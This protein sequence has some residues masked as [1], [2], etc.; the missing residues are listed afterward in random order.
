[1]RLLCPG[2]KCI[3]D[4]NTGSTETQVPPAW[5][6]GDGGTEMKGV[7][8]HSL[9]HAVTHSRCH[10]TPHMTYVCVCVC[11]R[12][13]MRV[14][15]RACL[16]ACMRAWVRACVCAHVLFVC[17]F[18]VVVSTEQIPLKQTLQCANM[19]IVMRYQ[20]GLPEDQGGLNVQAAALS[21]QSDPAM[22]QR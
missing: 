20:G 1:M 8:V 5:A 16:R 6:V 15:L 4:K 12:A 19:C 21:F 3:T 10:M 13:C 7:R 18:V 2:T 17:L 22:T 9:S 14:C 11:V